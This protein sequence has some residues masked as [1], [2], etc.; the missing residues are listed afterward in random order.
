MG[1]GIALKGHIGAWVDPAAGVIGCGMPIGR[2]GLH[3]LAP[4]EPSVLAGST[5][6]GKGIKA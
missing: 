2:P 6:P 3:G 5:L 1:A 4:L